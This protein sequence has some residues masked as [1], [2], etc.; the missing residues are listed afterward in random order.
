[1]MP[2]TLDTRD[3]LAPT[4]NPGAPLLPQHDLSKP[5]RPTFRIQPTRDVARELGR[6]LSAIA[7]KV[8]ATF[9]THRGTGDAE[10]PSE[11]VIDLSHATELPQA[12]LILLVTLLRRIVGDRTTITLSGVRPMILGSL[13][14][15]DLPK[16]VVVVDTRGRRWTNA[17]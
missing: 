6:Y 1:M 8:Q 3:Q 11:L 5:V 13:V 10:E 12:Q 7:A 16:D 15:F 17:Q 14:A 2:T 4:E 9:D